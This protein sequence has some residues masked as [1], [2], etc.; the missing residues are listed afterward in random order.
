MANKVKSKQQG[1]WGNLPWSMCIC[2]SD[3]IHSSGFYAQLKGKLTTKQYTAATIFVDHF[4]RLHYVHLMTSLSSQ[5]TI[6][7]KQAFKQFASDHGVCIRQYHT[8]NGYF[9]D[10]AFKQHCSQQQQTIS[11]CGVNAHFQNGIAE[12]AIRDMLKPCSFMEK[13]DG[14]A[15][16]IF[17]CGR[18][19]SGWLCISIT[20]HQFYLMEDHILSYSMVSM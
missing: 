20:Q 5:D 12:R 16:C 10:N 7:A 6:D 4:S 19:Q 9:A 1:S 2:W 15:Q 13:Q 11:Y 3:A 14:Q 18:M 17:I 8:D